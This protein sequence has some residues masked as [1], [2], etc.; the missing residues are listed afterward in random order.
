MIWSPYLTPFE[1]T[2][3]SMCTKSR[4]WIFCT[5]HC[6]KYSVELFWHTDLLTYLLSVNLNGQGLG[7]EKAE[8]QPPS[9]LEFCSQ[10]ELAVAQIRKSAQIAKFQA[11]ETAIKAYNARVNVKKWKV[12]NRRKK[13]IT[14][15]L[16]TPQEFRDT[17]FLHYD[18]HAHAASG[19]EQLK[20]LFLLWLKQICREHFQQMPIE[21]YCVIC[22]GCLSR[23]S[24]S[25]SDSLHQSKV[26]RTFR[27][28]V[29]TQFCLATYSSSCPLSWFQ[30]RSM[31]KTPWLISVIYYNKYCGTNDK[32]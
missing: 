3:H 7:Q 27:T 5:S 9:A 24:G 32:Q 31:F 2:R 21:S 28:I 13:L 19:R 18:T 14:N 23:G 22:D 26:D 8:R 1:C 20:V 6:A 4:Q 30:Q 25:S 15:L 11:V 10:F 17:L 29:S 12:D 16:N